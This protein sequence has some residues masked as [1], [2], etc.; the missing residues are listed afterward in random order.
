M[1]RLIWG[2]TTKGGSSLLRYVL[3]PP[4]Q[5]LLETYK[6]GGSLFTETLVLYTK[7]II[8]A[9]RY[10]EDSDIYHVDSK[11]SVTLVSMSIDVW[12]LTTSASC[13]RDLPKAAHLRGIAIQTRS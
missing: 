2:I 10:G 7:I 13:D 6:L 4:Q 3:F 11:L 9:W 5:M 8:G 1:A 12:Q